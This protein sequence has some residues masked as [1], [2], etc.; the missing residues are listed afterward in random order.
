MSAMFCY[1]SLVIRPWSFV[2][3]PLLQNT[4][5]PLGRARVISGCK[6]NVSG[7][8]RPDNSL[9]SPI[10]R[11]VAGNVSTNCRLLYKCLET[12]S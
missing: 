7:K 2:I 9:I 8:T 12:V 6:A 10:C 11:D 1:S 3:R 5:N 4:G